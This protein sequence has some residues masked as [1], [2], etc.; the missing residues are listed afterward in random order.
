MCV[1]VDQPRNG[2]EAAGVHLLDV[3]VEA[4][5]VAHPADHLDA[6]VAAEDERVL[7]HLDRGELASPARD[8]AGLG[9]RRQLGEV[10]NEQPHGAR[11]AR[12]YADASNIGVERPSS[13]A[14]DSAS[15]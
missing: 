9:R 4:R 14:A 6:S 11:A 10:P 3:A 7:E 5:E 2:A 1:A 13:R 8:H 12:R 15:S